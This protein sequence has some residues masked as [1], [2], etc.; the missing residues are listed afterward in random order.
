VKKM[1]RYKLGKPQIKRLLEGK[2]VMDGHGRHFYAND[3]VKK[4]LH[5]I[6]DNNLYDKFDV[7]LEDGAM[8]IRKKE[9]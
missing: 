2:S 4:Y 7:I 1:S 3:E 5:K 9:M 8:D 6:H